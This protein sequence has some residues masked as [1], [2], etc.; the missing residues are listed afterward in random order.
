V[1]DIEDNEAVPDSVS[2]DDND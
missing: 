1:E 2:E